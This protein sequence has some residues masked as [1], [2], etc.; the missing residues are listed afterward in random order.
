MYDPRRPLRHG[1]IAHSGY[2]G[3]ENQVKMDVNKGH[4]HDGTN[5]KII[6]A[7]AS[8]FLALTDTP[9]SYAAQAGK[10]CKVNPGET[11]LI[12]DTP[13]GTGDVVGPASSTNNDI[14]L[15]DLATGK[16][17]KDSGKLLANSAN[18]IPVLDGSALLPLAQIPAT[19]TGKDADTLDT[20]HA[21]AFALT[22]KGVTNGDTHDHVGGDGAQIDHTGL[23][24]K[25]TN[26]HAQIDT[27][28]TNLAAAD[29]TN[30]NSHDHVGG[31]GAQI[32]HTG[33]SNKGTNT[34]AQ[35][36]TAIAAMKGYVLTVIADEFGAPVDSATYYFG[37][38]VKVWST[39]AL[40]APVY[41]P[42]AGNIKVAY[43]TWHGGTAGSN[44][45]ISLYLR[46]NNTTDTLIQTVGNA[47]GTKLFSNVAL[48]IA[49]VQ[50][51]YF[52]IKAVCP[53]WGTNPAAVSLGGQ[54]YIE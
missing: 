27:A 10:Y 14:V 12:F 5:S 34:H 36:D 11:A 44:E 47:N 48:N 24:N 33:L 23:S 49:V 42:K 17:I 21:S 22:A 20:L 31:D 15:F 28:L 46:L 19:L 37:S 18:N 39:V 13:T 9:A 30:G 2:L 6:A 40:Y 7:G 51:D 26:T 41:V 8:T 29:V 1:E 35:I 3:D 53:A 4:N 45:N 43:V 52:E 32:D 50:G 16:L 25:G 54:V 38:I